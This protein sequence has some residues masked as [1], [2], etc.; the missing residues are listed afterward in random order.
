MTAG[1]LVDAAIAAVAAFIAAASAES[2]C[3]RAA[4]FACAAASLARAEFSSVC[5][6]TITGACRLLATLATAES[7]ERASHASTPSRWPAGARMA[8]PTSAGVGAADVL[9]VGELDGGM[10]VADGDGVPL[11]VGG[12]G[13]C[14]C[15]AP[16]ITDG[17]TEC[18]AAT[19]ADA[20]EESE[21]DA[22]SEAEAVGDGLCEGA[23]DGEGEGGMPS[24]V[25]WCR[26]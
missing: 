4:S 19:V 12:G 23:G 15:E 16:G 6:A 26:T 3:A 2:P 13:V 22:A 7:K 8:D 17:G 24:T 14:E 9:G 11:G 21:C 20:E 5:P 1:L 18:D 10:Y 25:L